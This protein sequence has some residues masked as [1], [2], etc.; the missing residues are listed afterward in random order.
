MRG[1]GRNTGGDGWWR[2]GINYANT[3]LIYRVLKRT[4]IFN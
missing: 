1:S 2:E 3:G 4:K